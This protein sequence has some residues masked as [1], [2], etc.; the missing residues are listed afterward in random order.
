MQKYETIL[1][2]M[3]ATAVGYSVHTGDYPSAA[4]ITVLFVL[5]WLQEITIAINKAAH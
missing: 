4:V 5:S 3:A 1:N 2:I